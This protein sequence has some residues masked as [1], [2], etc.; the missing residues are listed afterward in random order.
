MQPLFYST[1]QVA[2]ELGTTRAA[3][4]IL[5]ETGA[6]ASETTAGGHLRIP[7]AEVKRFKRDGVP[8]IP[9][10]LPTDGP[11][12]PRNGH[13]SDSSPAV[14]EVASAADSVAIARSLLE[15]RRIERET[16]ENEDWFRE[17]EQQKLAA[18]AEERQRTDA[19]RAKQRRHKWVQEWMEYA[20]NSVPSDA[21]RAVEMEVYASV[22]EVLAG[23]QASQTAAITQ[24]LVDAAVHRVLGP[25]TRKQEM[26][27]AL[28][29]AINELPWD[30]REHS[31][32]RPLR[33]LAWEAA[34]E[35]IRILRNE[36][37]YRE[38]ETAAIQAVQPM[39]R[40]YNHHESCQRVIKRVYLFDATW[41][42]QEAAR[43]SVRRV[44][45]ALPIG[46]AA[47]ELEK[48]KDA[49]LAPYKAAVSERKEQARLEA[50]RKGQ[51]RAAELKAEL[52]LG[53]IASYLQREY[54]F[55]GGYAEMQ[56]EA[57]R[58]RPLI[59]C[60]LID[61]LIANPNLTPDQMRASI[62]E[63]IDGEV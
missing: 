40:A 34:A 17:R 53:H 47:K 3:V 2:R 7:E 36:V 21:R 48:A 51:R 44:L 9:R 55:Q 14:S 1:G 56:Q 8:S 41:E 49:V 31:E 59:R 43:E 61:Q 38:M 32:F 6:M 5:C 13:H 42:E 25:W 27:R 50:E 39:I 35:A 58:L 22:Q 23:L 19:E 26:E 18:E 4:R 45:A 16:E 28:H 60:V 12:P 46:A 52:Q 30:V 10:P 57:E 33:Q 29:W 20:M 63:Q 11:P 62:E 37:S 24:R 15:R 54:D